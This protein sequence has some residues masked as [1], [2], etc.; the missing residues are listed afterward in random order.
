MLGHRAA[1]PGNLVGPGTKANIIDPPHD[2]RVTANLFELQMIHVRVDQR[3]ELW[4]DAFADQTLAGRV[5]GISPTAGAALGMTTAESATG[6]FTKA[7]ARVV[8]KTR[9]GAGR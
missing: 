7:A 5:A 1:Y 8:V 3:A 9:A 4:V 6:T 2:V